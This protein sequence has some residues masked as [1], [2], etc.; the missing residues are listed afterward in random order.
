MYC[1][2]C[3][4]LNEDD[5]MFCASCG[6][7]CGGATPPNPYA[8]GPVSQAT[9]SGYD[10]LVPN[11]IATIL[12]CMP[13]GVVGIVYSALARG[14]RGRGDIAEAIAKTKTAKLMFWLAFGFGIVPVIFGVIAAIADAAGTPQ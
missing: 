4:A 9:N 5:A 10:Y 8:A 12:C 11:I 13:L 14:A 7:P 6:A 2:S 3:G 1:K